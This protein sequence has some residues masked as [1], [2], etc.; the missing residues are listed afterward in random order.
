M[1]SKVVSY[2]VL[3]IFHQVLHHIECCLVQ[4][5]LEDRPCQKR[6]VRFSAKDEFCRFYMGVEKVLNIYFNSG[7]NKL[8]GRVSSQCN[9][10]GFLDA[11]AR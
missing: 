11:S 1:R 5:W 10:S 8:L 6:I 3:T 9:Y 2:F 4:F 7:N